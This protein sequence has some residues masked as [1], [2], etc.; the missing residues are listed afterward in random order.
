MDDMI[1]HERIR[2]QLEFFK[3][4]DQAVH[5]LFSNIGDR[6]T[7]FNGKVQTILPDQFVIVDRKKGASLVF[8]DDIKE[9]SKFGGSL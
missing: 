6:N 2:K 1:R 9:L 4:Q 5:V 7:F 8:F 3:S